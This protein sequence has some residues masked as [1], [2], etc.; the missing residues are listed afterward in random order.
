MGSLPFS[1]TE[2]F[3]LRM[4]HLILYNQ[5]FGVE[6]QQSSEHILA[7][8]P[9]ANLNAVALRVDLSQSRYSVLCAL[10]NPSAPVTC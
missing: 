3:S 1:V 10:G 2:I 9:L 5:D 7:A 8:V 4:M 6:T